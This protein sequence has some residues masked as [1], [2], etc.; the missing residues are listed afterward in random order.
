MVAT[1]DDTADVVSSWSERLENATITR[2]PY[3]F[4]RPLEG[5]QLEEQTYS[6]AIPELGR[7]TADTAYTVT[8]TAW[9]AL[10][11]R[12]TDNEEIV[13]YANND[14]VLRIN[15]SSE[16]S[17]QAL[18][19][20]VST[21][22]QSVADMGKGD[23]DAVS[24][25]MKAKS[26]LEKTPNIFTVGIV[27][28]ALAINLGRFHHNVIDCLL[29]LEGGDTLSIIYNSL[30]YSS[31][32]IEI[33]GE[34]LRSLI[35]AVLN[36]NSDPITSISLVTPSVS[37]ILPDP[38]ANLHWDKYRGS[39]QDIFQDN[40]VKCAEKTCVIETPGNGLETSRYFTYRDIDQA[41]NIVAHYLID[42]GIKP[43]DVVT[44]YSSRSVELICS[45]MGV[46]KAGGTF[47][48]IDPAYP[49]E[50]QNIYLKVAI[51]KV[52]IV[53]ASAGTLSDVVNDFI[54]KELNVLSIIPAVKMQNDG[55]ILGGVISGDS[56][57]CFSKV[58]HLKATRTGVTVGPDS[59]PTLSFTSGS[60]GIP[61]G[62]LGRAF[63]LAYYFD[64]MA[65]R[66]SL[67]PND[68]F[69]MLS[70][71]AHDPIQRD[72]FTPL[73]FGAQILIPSA[74]DIGTPGKL[75]QWMA[76][77]GATVTHLTPAM[78]QL[79]TAHATV[80][81]PK[82]HHAFFVGD[83]L[84]KRDCTTLQKL[85]KNANIVNMYGTTE[86]QRAVSYFEVKPKAIEPDFLEKVKD[87]I[88][89]GRGMV[90]VQLLVVNRKD[91]NK[92]C[93]VGEVGELYVRAGG[94]AEG[95][96]GLPEL[97]KEKFLENWFVN[98]NHWSS[99]CAPK[100]NTWGQ[101][102]FGPRDRL[103]RTGDLGRYLPDGNC[104]CCGRADDQVKIRGFRIELGEID[105]AVSR[106]PLIRE[107][108]TLVRENA[109][110]EPTLITFLIPRFEKPE[111]KQFT[112]DV[113]E[114]IDD[115]TVLGWLRYEALIADVKAYLKK[116]LAL[117]AIPPV[118]IIMNKLP[119]NP[120]GKVDKPK[121]KYPCQKQFDLLAKHSTTVS[122]TAE[123]KAICDIWQ[124]VLPTK[125]TKI[126]R[127]DTFFDLGGHSILATKMIFTLR[128]K[129]NLEIPL[130]TIF[131][132]PT[133]KLF[134]EE[135]SRIKNLTKADVPVLNEISEYANDAAKL[136]DTMVAPSYPSRSSIIQNKEGPA[137]VNVFLTGA[138]GFLGSYILADILNRPKNQYI[139][140]VYAHVRAS[141]ATEG[142]KRLKGSCKA[143][144]TWCEEFESRIEI[145][146]GDLSKKNFGL[147]E[148]AWEE[149]ANKIDVIIHN[150]ALVHWVYPYS[151]LRDSNVLSTINVMNLAALNKAKYFTFVSSTSTLDTEHYYELS[152]KILKEGKS[153]LLE[154]DDLS[155][156]KTGLSG[157]YGQSKWAAEYVV[158][159]AGKR[160]LR[161]CIVRPGYV[162]GASNNGS[163]NPDDFLLRLMKGCI[164][165]GA[166]PDIK[167]PVNMLPVDHVAHIVTA[168]SFH[169]PKTD[170]IA[171]ANVTSKQQLLLCDF[172]HSLKV[173][174]YHL[175]MEPYES[176]KTLLEETATDESN[177]LYPLLH[178][179]L[180]RLPE[181]TRTP[182]L[183]Y[184]NTMNS[185]I[186]DGADDK[187]VKEINNG[188]TN[189]QC[190]IYIS[191]LRKVGY[192]PS[193]TSP[194]HESKKLPE[195]EISDE[196]VKL[197]TSGAAT[198][199]SAV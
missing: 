8:L 18:L 193:P 116:R 35:S 169:P 119:L 120:N 14:K 2:L 99:I 42:A 142:L 1:N 15:V 185:L 19:T 164:Q 109:A 176:W 16:M 74:D 152:E 127:D 5:P 177:S 170:E 50:R 95:Y 182:A 115:D 186:R 141:N 146:L 77:Y 56:D 166:A 191:F 66:F 30:L 86:T 199:S 159:N 52:V 59:N 49:P 97:N 24:E 55:T 178:F 105:T 101:F 10:L 172:L 108:I 192:L 45:I 157:G 173:Y 23:F 148:H 130:G 117:Y 43:Q 51:P 98:K 128:N 124:E 40:A 75:A 85:A 133:I 87:V 131:K 175:R 171:V 183:D 154:S 158:R 155:G 110:D 123:E 67:S 129:L 31:T 26:G 3:D 38:T 195:I 70:G 20:A 126:S 41:S 197:V 68:K 143:Y 106:H 32:R 62:V 167:N 64:W 189:E 22:L 100:D 33:M 150:A 145:V 137:K 104:E 161:G 102:W 47:S 125:T 94:L 149:L 53:I 29:S 78:G 113:N 91:R 180:D 84:T 184:S 138:T 6:H 136:M 69:T 162:T 103:Y 11:Y 21:E 140:K 134:T 63:S 34:Q 60:E 61:K 25:F 83:I 71:I 88:P 174:G 79:L 9:V 153:G 194:D 179:V 76:D 89:A 163:S 107:N 12:F 73:F 80:P 132:Y 4:S 190:G 187:L 44:I 118:I 111:I 72:I 48:V 96:R 92:L 17:F 36:K 160:G 198:R 168:A 196:Q 114:P 90:D 58:N 81:F 181:N 165:I 46:L 156:S 122:L 28:G 93:G 139:T 27:S 151:K 112:T 135:I 121:L 37:G 65:E 13:L 147:E 188:V 54:A 39:I 82:L 57:D 7:L 144:G